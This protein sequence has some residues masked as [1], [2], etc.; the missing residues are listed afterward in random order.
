MAPPVA[1]EVSLSTLPTHVALQGSEDRLQ[2]ILGAMRA[3]GGGAPAG[4]WGAVKTSVESGALFG[5]S[6]ILGGGA[7]KASAAAPPAT[8]ASLLAGTAADPSVPAKKAKKKKKKAAPSAAMATVPSPR[9]QRDFYTRPLSEQLGSDRPISARGGADALRENGAVATKKP[10]KKAKK[11]SPGTTDLGPYAATSL[12]GDGASSTASSAAGAKGKKAAR[13]KSALKKERA[14]VE[15]PH[16]LSTAAALEAA[17]S[18]S[19]AGE[20]SEF[21]AWA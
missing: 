7:T 16:V 19:V 21:S 8:A 13:P 5:R 17:R 15:D 14:H 2:N 9:Q 4:M 10:A 6:H 3:G 11:P 18:V 1:E 20:P 12:W